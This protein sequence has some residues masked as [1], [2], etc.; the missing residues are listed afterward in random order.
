VSGTEGPSGGGVVKRARF[1]AKV[2]TVR[3]AMG[4]LGA[5]MLLAGAGGFA[6]GMW[7]AVEADPERC[8]D[9]EFSGPSMLA[10]RWSV[11][12]AAF[13]AD[14]QLDEEPDPEQL[15]RSDYDRLPEPG[16]RGVR[17]PSPDAKRTDR[18]KRPDHD[19]TVTID[20]DLDDPALRWPKDRPTGDRTGD[21]S[22]F[23]TPGS[24]RP[25]HTVRPDARGLD[26]R[27]RQMLEAA[28]QT[29]ATACKYLEKAHPLAPAKG[30]DAANRTAIKHLRKAQG[31]YDAVLKRTLPKSLRDRLEVRITDVQ[32]R[33]FWALRH[34]TIR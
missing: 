25:K 5:L 7:D 2:H 11:H 26:K 30:R 3:K 34:S 27:T 8:R 24:L 14:L 22:A 31:Q 12:A 16:R 29:F 4:I 33:L 23:K 15:V 17:R 6:H 20:P 9:L 1:R 10:A 13:I 28:D 21:T 32:R 19:P 18:E